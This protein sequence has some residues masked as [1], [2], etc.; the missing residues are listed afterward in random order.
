MLETNAAQLT[1]PT[2]LSSQVWMSVA[3]IPGRRIT[4]D[5]GSAGAE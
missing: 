3:D 4:H 2:T 5:A 1:A